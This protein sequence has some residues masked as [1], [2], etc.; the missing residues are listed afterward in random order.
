MRLLE[1]YD[2]DFVFGIPGVHTLEL[3]RGLANSRMRPITPRHEQGA[4]FMADGYARVTGK[5]GV[6]ILITGPGLTNAAT[7]I[8]QAYSDSIP[9]LVVSSVNARSDLG[10]GRGRLHEISEQR[11][12]IAPIVGSSQTILDPRDL[13]EAMA[14]A[15]AAFEGQRPRPA[16][17]EIPIDALDEPADFPLQRRAPVERQPPTPAALDRAAEILIAAKRIFVILGGGTVHAAEAMRTL[18][19]RLKVPVATTTAGKGV[20]PEDHPLCVGANLIGAPTRELLA[21]ADVVMA[22]GTELAETDHYSGYL[23]IK[24]RLI[25]VDIDAVGITRDYP[26]TVAVLADAGLAVEALLRRLD[27]YTPPALRLAESKRAV[28]GVLTRMEQNESPVRRQHRRLLG[29]LREALPDDGIVFSDM[30]QIAYSGNR[31]YR[32]RQ[33]LTWFHPNGYGTLGFALPA[34]IGAKL[35]KPRTPVVALV[36]DGGLQ[37]TVQELATA[38]ELE[39]PLAV[40]LWC[41]G[42]Y[43]QIRDGLRQRGVPPI[44]VNLR[45]PDHRLLAEAYGCRF[46]RPEGLD[47]FADAVS[48]SA[49]AKAPTVIEVSEG[50]EFLV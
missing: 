26:P 27:G 23:P 48:A 50:A 4:G 35:G 16:H 37:F 9:M 34:A 15:F 6:L 46:V 7:P 29:A 30:T 14:R 28:S 24:G 47:A 10:M 38:A 8:A 39:L 45:S 17:I 43:G 18:I 12:V 22:I 11:R 31:L 33:P 25:R 13:P 3:Y 49:T 2:V 36:G 19:D 20:V 5:P 1:A 44:G 41:N 21:E 32:C 42:G 40:V